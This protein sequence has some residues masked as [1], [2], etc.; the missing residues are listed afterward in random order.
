MTLIECNPT[1]YQAE[2]E[3][4][5]EYYKCVR[6]YVCENC[7]KTF[8]EIVKRKDTN[9]KKKCPACNKMTLDSLI[10]GDVVSFVKEI[11]TVGQLAEQNNK[12]LGK[13]GVEDK[14]RNIKHEKKAAQQELVEQSQV[15]DPNKCDVGGNNKNKTW[16]NPTGK[17]LSELG[18][19][20]K[21]AQ[22]E[23][24]M[25]GKVNKNAK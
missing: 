19:L 14:I 21:A 17:D 10:M 25:T 16:Y 13:Y 5:L 9:F 7:K 8:A 1:E 2:V 6:G 4:D 23:Y 18:G 15:L 3:A 11:R 24:I 12:K 22:E 20:S